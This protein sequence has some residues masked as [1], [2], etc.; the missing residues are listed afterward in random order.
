MNI[1]DT[2]IDIC[3][4]FWIIFTVGGGILFLLFI[5]GWLT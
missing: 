5:S 1:L 3:V 2:L 4:F